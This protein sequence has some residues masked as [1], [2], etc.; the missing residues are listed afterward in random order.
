MRRTTRIFCA[1]TLFGAATLAAAI[2]AGLFR[3]ADRCVLLTAHGAATPEVAPAL[4][5][6]PGFDRLR[7]RFDEMLSWNEA[8]APFHPGGWAPRADDVPLWERYFRQRWGLGD[9]TV[10]LVVESPHAP[11]GLALAQLFPDSP[12]DAYAPGLSA[13]GPTGTRL[14]PLVGT[15]VRRLLHPDLVPGLR[16]LLLGEFDV[17]PEPVPTDALLKVLG[18]LSDAVGDAGHADGER[19]ALLLGQPLAALDLVTGAQEEELYARMVRGAAALGHRR[20]VFA[21]HPEAPVRWGRA[22]Q[23]EAAAAGVELT[24]RSEPAAAEAL[25]A[26]LRPALVVGCFSSALLTAPALFGIPAAR[27][28]TQELLSRLSPYDDPNRVPL[29]L[30]D[31]LLPDLDAAA[32]VA[33]W[34]MP[35]AQAVAAEVAGLLEAV[36]FCMHPKTYPSLRPVAET[37]LAAHLDAHTSRYFKRRRLASLALPGGL[38]AQLTALAR[39]TRVRRMA[40]RARAL[41]RTE[42]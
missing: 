10:E 15:R 36:A 26:A 12:V 6:L 22:L 16:P 17:A 14:D 27:V 41:G 32:D 9:D 8:I 35:T 38:P 7:G 20:L 23:E 37:Y 2:D 3:P 31:A 21:P 1:G 13:Y 40:R 11:P 24:V 30:A 29:T 33:G 19:P 34:R 25:F 5:K 4:T 28:G 18:E 42:R 39:N